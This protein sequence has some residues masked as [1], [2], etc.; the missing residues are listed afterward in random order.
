MIGGDDMEYFPTTIWIFHNELPSKSRM[1]RLFQEFP[2]TIYENE[3]SKMNSTLFFTGCK[4]VDWQ[5][6]A[7][8]HPLADIAASMLYNCDPQVIED[9]FDQ[10]LEAYYK[11]FQET[12]KSL[13]IEPPFSFQNLRED[14]EKK[15]FAFVFA[16]T[17]FFYDPI[18][19]EEKMMKRVRYILEK[20][21]KHTP[22][23]FQ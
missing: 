23:L 9:G 14:M 11:V 7:G 18:C 4:I 17:L 22:E 16:V 13:K 5:L 2:S 8:A 10:M 21:L 12:C 20:S 19:R 6:C 15:G 1:F 3:T